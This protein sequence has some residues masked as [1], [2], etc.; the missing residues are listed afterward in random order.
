MDLIADVMQQADILKLKTATLKLKGFADRKLATAPGE[1]FKKVN[2]MKSPSVIEHA[3]SAIMTKDQSRLS[4]TE[5]TDLALKTQKLHTS[6]KAAMRGLEAVLATKMVE[7]MMPKDQSD[8]YGK[9]T[10]GEIWRG[11]H[12]DQMG[13]ALASKGLFGPPEAVVTANDG[14]FLQPSRAKAIVPF[15]G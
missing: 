8:V 9:G 4:G 14:R 3:K 11:F 15:A 2:S 7:S 5:N 1:A 13:K 12:I 6:K 10:A